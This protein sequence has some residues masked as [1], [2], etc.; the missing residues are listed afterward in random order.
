MVKITETILRDAH[1]S[2][3]ATRMKTE[4]MVPIL[5]ELD[6]AG[7][8]S[9]EMW[10]GATF[11]SCLRFLSE[12]PWERLRIIREKVKNT[13]LQMLL[14]GQNVVGYRHYADDVVYRFVE[15]AAKNGIDIFRIFDALNDINN[16]KIA[17]KAVKESGKH[18]QGCISYTL[19]PVHTEERYLT[20]ASK[21]KDHGADSI[22]IK[23][24]AGLMTPDA[25]Y[26]LVKKLK[27]QI[28]LPVQMHTHC[29]S[30][31]A[32]MTYFRAVQAGA[33]VL[34]CA[35]SPFAWGTSQPPTESV[36]H[37][38]KGT[39]WESE[40]EP[41]KLI[42]LTDY[43]KGIRKKYQTLINPIS[44]RVDV[45]VLAYQIPGGMLSNLV[46][47]LEKQKKLDKYE[48]VLKEVPKVR[49][50]LGYPPLVTPTSQIVGTQAVMNVLSGERY[51]MITKET[52]NY[53]KGMY[54]KTPAKISSE[55]QKKIIG[56]D[57]LIKG[58][59]ADSLD[60]ELPEIEK[61]YKDIINKPEDV[62]SLALYTEIA[63]KFLR[64][65]TEPEAIPETKENSSTS[66]P[67][68]GKA[69]SGKSSG[70]YTVVVNGKS[71]SV[72]VIPAG[73]GQ[74]QVSNA[75]QTAAAKPQASG[76]TEVKAP[77]QGN[78]WKMLVSPGDLIEEGETLMILEAMKMENEISAPV[79][80]TVNEVFVKEG[81]PVEADDLLV[82]IG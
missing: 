3:I 34:D 23:D 1:Q 25:A 73:S 77:L 29:T 11:D 51:R 36:V 74:A 18:I 56:D 27:E 68:S 72:D 48:E 5:E 52:K 59:P 57:S 49:K 19:S 42:P 14:R 76:G 81:D 80:G 17:M 62:I 40:V 75:V 45:D 70:S 2:L 46:S 15:L 67:S 7:Y 82:E 24:M 32:M 61:Q 43:F 20:F 4:D 58:R 71:F 47:Q 12:D 26:S 31:L 41:D 6:K 10:G 65:E 21:L 78:V 55:M 33:D 16:I 44:E 9:L 50:E 35:L 64:G 54:G 28:E 63:A 39:K 69:G 8:H 22:C 79:S 60:P 38:L 53:I 13:K 30:G 37:G 66:V